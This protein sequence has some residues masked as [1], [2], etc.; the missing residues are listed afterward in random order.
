MGTI[1][2]SNAI[3]A[4]FLP[5]IP[6]DALLVRH[7][8]CSSPFLFLAVDIRLTSKNFR[9]THCPIDNKWASIEYSAGNPYIFMHLETHSL[10]VSG[11][12]EKKMNRE[13]SLR[14]VTGPA[15]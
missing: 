7:P 11:V 13:T 9:V 10:E 8:A 15:L 5:W 14:V 4:L 12:L 3:W 1:G 6:A 2:S